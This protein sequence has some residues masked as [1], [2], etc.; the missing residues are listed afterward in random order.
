[1]TEC[2]DGVMGRAMDELDRLSASMM[3][4]AKPDPNSSGSSGAL[5]PAK[6]VRTVSF[7][8]DRAPSSTPPSKGGGVW[9]IG[10]YCAEMLTALS[11]LGVDS[12]EVRVWDGPRSSYSPELLVE[13]R[14]DWLLINMPRAMIDAPR[15]GDFAARM[16]RR[17][18]SLLDTQVESG[19]QFVMY[20]NPCWPT[21]DAQKAP[22]LKEC[23]QKWHVTELRWC[24]MG[25]YHPETGEGFGCTTKVLSSIPL[26]DGP[27]TPDRCKCLGGPGH[28]MRP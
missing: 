7:A 15:G 4:K 5:A 23:M 26:T 10:D 8:A 21:W 19:G 13:Q 25:V 16:R 2:I 24:Q 9:V 18:A 6:P 20:G 17:I 12:A 28:V 3:T 22:E 1:M 11:V 27:G 14:P